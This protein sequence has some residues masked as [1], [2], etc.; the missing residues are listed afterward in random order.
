MNARRLWIV[1]AGKRVRETALP[2]ILSLPDSFTIAGVLA[3]TSRDVEMAGRRF[4]IRALSQVSTQEF[5]PGDVVYVAAA[6]D[7][8]PSVL[9]HF[10]T[11]DRS[12]LELLIDTPVLRF[13]HLRFA[14]LLE[15]WSRAS[16]A[17]DVAWLPWYET[18]RAAV[19]DV[20]NV[21]FDRSAYAYHGFAAA[22]TLCHAT[23]VVHAR[24]ARLEGGRARR[25]VEVDGGRRAIMIEPRDYATGRFVLEG[26]RGRVTD[27]REP[28][29]DALLL[30]PIVEGG[31]CTGFRAGEV[32]TNL[33]PE[34]SRL[35][36][37]DPPGASVV[38]RMPSMKCIG[39]RRLAASVAAGRGAYPIQQGLDDTAVDWF[40]ERLGRWHANGILDV[41]R[42]LARRLW[43]ALGRLG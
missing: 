1:G 9:Q 10:A 23:R 5:E 16:V 8:V 39:F 37:G 36:R 15:G 25:E 33:S 38:A 26:T 35:T 22:K 28:G 42:P 21:L 14:P 7:A 11:F 3:R 41:H 43:S 13:K 32:V 30:E 31:V 17:E 24:R 4:A 12:R 40:L 29:E 34:E 27:R 18:A 20:R 2:A 6:K 19:G